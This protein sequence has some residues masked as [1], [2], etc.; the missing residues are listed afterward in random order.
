MWSYQT[1]GPIRSSPIVANGSVFVNSMDG[2]T[3]ALNQ[4]TGQLEWRTHIGK[5]Y[6]SSPIAYGDSIYTGSLYAGKLYRLNASNGAQI[7]NSTLKNIGT[8]FL[9]VNRVVYAI[10]ESGQAGTLFAIDSKTGLSSWSINTTYVDQM[11]YS[12]GRLYLEDILNGTISAIDVLTHSTTWKYNTN[13]IAAGGI[14]VA[15]GV[16]YGGGASNG[17]GNFTAL[18]ATTGT[19]FWSKQIGAIGAP[20]VAYGMIVLNWGHG[21]LTLNQ[22]DGSILWF[23]NFGSIGI[24]GSI[25]A[26]ADRLAIAGGGSLGEIPDPTIYAYDVRSGAIVWEFPVKLGANSSPAV[27]NGIIYV[28]DEAGYLYAIGAA[29]QNLTLTS[30]LP[31]IIIAVAASVSFIVLRRFKLRRSAKQT[32]L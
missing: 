4:Q 10:N 25:P 31:F 9:V 3:Y 20:A 16:L 2:F 21:V 1:G 6:D 19:P 23:S 7:W 22:T 26:V 14:T 30:A 17:G 5:S 11:A 32:P 13:A 12:Q 18:N 29:S 28:G 27:S 24:P 8:Q 15:E